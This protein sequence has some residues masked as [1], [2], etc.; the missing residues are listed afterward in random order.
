M[1]GYVHNVGILC[2]SELDDNP[3][4]WRIYGD[5][6]RGI[7]LQ[8][9]MTKIVESERYYLR[10]PFE[11]IYCDG[12]KTAWDPLADKEILGRQLCEL[13]YT[14]LYRP[15]FAPV[16]P[17]EYPEPVIADGERSPLGAL[18]AKSAQQPSPSRKRKLPAFAVPSMRPKARGYLRSRRRAPVERS[19]GIVR[20][21][22]RSI[23]PG[24]LQR[25]CA[26]TRRIGLALSGP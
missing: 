18:L 22:R 1:Q 2:I 12:P 10:G 14:R 5:D 13:D 25:C 11:G 24:K 6:G 23:V 17:R 20:D 7:C 3:E 21:R 26:R 15:G 19:P 8:L 16:T 9:D 4:L